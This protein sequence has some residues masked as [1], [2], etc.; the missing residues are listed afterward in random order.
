MLRGSCR[1]PFTHDNEILLPDVATATPKPRPFSI[2][3]RFLVTMAVCALKHM[4]TARY[5]EYVAC[6]HRSVTLAIVG[7]RHSMALA[8]QVCYLRFHLTLRFKVARVL[9]ICTTSD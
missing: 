1:R 4:C 6:S 2:N 3:R 8:Y 9:L 5:A 7:K